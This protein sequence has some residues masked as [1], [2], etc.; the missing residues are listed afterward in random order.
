MKLRFFLIAA[1]LVPLIGCNSFVTQA[2]NTL[3]GA[4]GVIANEQIA[5]KTQCTATPSASVC[6][7]IN[8]AIDAQNAAISG[9][10]AYCQLPVAPDAATLQAK[11]AMV[12]NVNPSAKAVFVAE[13][14]ALSKIVAQIQGQ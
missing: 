6:L 5:H 9:L 2:V 13:L 7:S 3:A 4:Q 11:G 8:Q 12:C 14:S 10:E 1:L